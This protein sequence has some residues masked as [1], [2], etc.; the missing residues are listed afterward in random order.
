MRTDSMFLD[1]LD[2]DSDNLQEVA[3]LNGGVA[4]IHCIAG[5]PWYCSWLPG[6]DMWADPYGLTG[7]D[8][9]VPQDGAL[10]I[11][12]DMYV[13]PDNHASQL[14]ATATT[15][16]IVNIL[17]RSSSYSGPN[18]A[19]VGDVFVKV[20]GIRFTQD[21]EG[22]LYDDAGEFY[23]K[24]WVDT[25][26]G[27]GYQYLGQ[28]DLTGSDADRYENHWYTGNTPST[29]SVELPGNQPYLKIKIEV[30]DQDVWPDGDDNCKTLYF[31]SVVLSNDIDGIEAVKCA[32]SDGWELYLNVCGFASNPAVSCYQVNVYYEKMH[33]DSDNDGWPNGDGE[34]YSKTWAGRSGYEKYWCSSIVTR[35][36]NTDINHNRY[37]VQNLYMLKNKGVNLHII[38]DPKDDDGVLGEDDMAGLL[39]WT[40]L[41][42]SYVGG[43]WYGWTGTD[44]G[45]FKLNV[46]FQVNSIV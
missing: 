15:T 16:D 35:G 7:F 18:V 3:D 1:W 6:N 27:A 5:N 31:D 26:N 20:K 32:S 36:D 17:G 33:V 12:S 42:D 2:I 23:Y 43:A 4:S 29:G 25:L 21:V 11:G 45:D 10:L 41:V 37:L 22:I 30:W 8:A 19:I 39:D 34:I 44:F 9:L 28:I 14:Y 40:G 24:V 13:V 46:R 38:V